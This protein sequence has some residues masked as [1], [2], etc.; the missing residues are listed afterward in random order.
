MPF[1]DG[2][3]FNVNIAVLVALRRTNGSK[4]PD[5][6]PMMM[7]STDC[8]ELLLEKSVAK[9]KNDKR[10]KIDDRIGKSRLSH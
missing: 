7:L 10:L 8:G 5:L 6:N 4:Y 9:T 2:N 1:M 3:R